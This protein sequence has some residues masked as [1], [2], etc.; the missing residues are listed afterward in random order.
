MAE[1]HAALAADARVA[2]KNVDGNAFQAL[3]ECRDLIAVRHIERMRLGAQL[4]QAR[5][6]R[7]V[8]HRGEHA[9]AVLRVLAREL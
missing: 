3:R 4:L 2:E 9:P 5:F 1:R 8:T 7:G 6:R